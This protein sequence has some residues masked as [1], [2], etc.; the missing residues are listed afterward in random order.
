MKNKLFLTFF[1]PIFLYSQNLEVGRITSKYNLNGIL[2][3]S[4]WNIR[5]INNLHIDFEL[6]KNIVRLPY[7]NF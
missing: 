7:G 5:T 3:E 6:T 1:F 4:F 2:T